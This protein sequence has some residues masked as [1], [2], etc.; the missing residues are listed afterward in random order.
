MLVLLWYSYMR[1]R[2]RSL[3]STGLTQSISV[4]FVFT[5]CAI[6]AN[7][8]YTKDFL[9]SA[10]KA[11]HSNFQMFDKVND[12]LYKRCLLLY[13]MLKNKNLTNHSKKTKSTGFAR[14]FWMFDSRRLLLLKI[15]QMRW[16]PLRHMMVGG[17]LNNE[18]SSKKTQNIINVEKVYEYSSKWT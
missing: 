9:N 14:T 12:D 4:R 10:F 6:I 16:N 1:Y 15:V 17:G 13:F 7:Q 8:S 2:L 3:S 18:Y 11:R 5:Y